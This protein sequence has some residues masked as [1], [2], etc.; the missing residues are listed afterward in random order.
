VLAVVKIDLLETVYSTQYFQPPI[1]D[2]RQTR[3]VVLDIVIR[4]VFGYL[5]VDSRQYMQV[6]SRREG[7]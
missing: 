4:A 1:G 6:S 7:K 2:L 5:S 3:V